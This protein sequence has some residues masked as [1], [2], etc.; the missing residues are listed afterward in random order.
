MHCCVRSVPSLLRDT[1]MTRFMSRMLRIRDRA[2]AARCCCRF[3]AAAKA[4]GVA[5]VDIIGD[6]YFA[7][8]GHQT[9]SVDPLQ[10]THMV[11]QALDMLK[12]RPAGT[13]AWRA[14]VK[15]Q[16]AQHWHDSTHGTTHVV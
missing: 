7:I 4:N 8:S 1:I 6:A 3:D 10:A 14:K 11:R 5:K 15:D 9:R 12:V 16:Q 13:F 2:D